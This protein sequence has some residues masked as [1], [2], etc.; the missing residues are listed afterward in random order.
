M[1]DKSTKTDSKT[2]STKTTKVS[3]LSP[4]PKEAERQQAIFTINQ[5]IQDYVNIRTQ[6]DQYQAELDNISAQV[7]ALGI[8]HDIT[9]VIGPTHQVSIVQGTN[10]QLSTTRL[11]ELGVDPAVI[12]SAYT[13]RPTSYIKVSPV[14]GSR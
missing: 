14:E 8:L 7:Q 5:L 9:K 3:G 2:D 10:R 4:D 12:Q 6:R 1:A 13:V 11:I